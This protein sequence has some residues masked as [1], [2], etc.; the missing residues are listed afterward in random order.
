[1]AIDSALPVRN[2]MMALLKADTA[3][4]AIVPATRG[5]S[6]TAP[7]AP[8]FPFWR[9]GAPTPVPVRGTCIDGAEITVSVDG[10]AKD[11]RSSSRVTD[12]AE[13]VAGRLG[14]AIAAALDGQILTLAN[15]RARVRWTGS[16]VRRDGDDASAFMAVCNFRVRAITAR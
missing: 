14:A 1:M 13:D 5:Y 11:I 10:F 2:A 3:V 9:Y 16:L 12:R 4:L 8:T 7:A 6:Q 15:G